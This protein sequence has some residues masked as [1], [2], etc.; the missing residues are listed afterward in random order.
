MDVTKIINKPNSGFEAADAM[1][2]TE[3]KLISAIHLLEALI[4]FPG[5]EHKEFHAN[6]I[7]K[8]L[9]QFK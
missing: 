3:Q 1:I 4:F 7:N 9:E 8:F 6:R 5:D 2:K